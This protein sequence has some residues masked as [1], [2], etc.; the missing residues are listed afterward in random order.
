MVEVEV[1]V[2]VEV[3]QHMKRNLSDD[4]VILILCLSHY[5][6]CSLILSLDWKYLHQYSTP[7]PVNSLLINPG[8]T[9]NMHIKILSFQTCHGPRRCRRSTWARY[10][11]ALSASWRP[12][13]TWT[14]LTARRAICV[15]LALTLRA[16]SRLVQHLMHRYT[17]LHCTVMCGDL[18]CSSCSHADP[19]DEVLLVCYW[20][21]IKSTSVLYVLYSTLLYYTLLYSVRSSAT[22]TIIFN[23]M[24]TDLSDT[25]TTREFSSIVKSLTLDV[26][27]QSSPLGAGK[28]C[29]KLV[30][31]TLPHE[32]EQHKQQNTLCNYRFSLGL[33]WQYFSCR[34]VR[35]RSFVFF[36]P[37]PSVLDRSFTSRVRDFTTDKSSRVVV[38][39]VYW[40]ILY[41]PVLPLP[42]RWT[43]QHC[44]PLYVDP[45]TAP[46]AHNSSDFNL[47]FSYLHSFHTLSSL[48]IPHISTVFPFCHF[49]PFPQP[50]SLYRFLIPLLAVPS[51]VS[52]S[53][54][55][56]FPA[57][58][59][60]W[61]K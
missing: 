12:S 47:F 42:T 17:I 31:W 48:F 14:L 38:V 24:G 40:T 15:F 37:A 8:I 49:L 6:Y 39:S 61:I 20:R 55:L 44:L 57:G 35:R 41:P 43:H 53:F 56:L 58:Q 3:G 27:D 33:F 19:C 30:R 21:C 60:L 5:L 36:L 46:C 18:C 7:S 22:S 26:R 51:A 13:L 50:I 4:V 23:P 29:I 1:E 54:T 59:G 28:K 45:C 34:R 9:L 2:E 52:P 11:D 16:L 32:T 10:Q 25:T